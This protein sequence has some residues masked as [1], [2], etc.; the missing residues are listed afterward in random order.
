MLAAWW[1]RPNAEERKRA[2]WAILII[3]ALLSAFAVWNYLRPEGF[4]EWLNG[5]GVLTFRTDAIVGGGLVHRADGTFR[6]GGLL[7]PNTLGYTALV[8]VC[9]VVGRVARN[10]VKRLDAA[11]GLLCAVA[12][13]MTGS[14]SAIAVLPVVGLVIAATSG[15][16]GRAVGVA[17]GTAVVLFI[18]AGLVGGVGETLSS[19]TD[20]NNA[21]TSRHIDA[22]GDGVERIRTRPFGSGLGTASS[23]ALKYQ[24]EGAQFY[25]ESALI[26]VG[27]ETGVIGLVAFLVFVGATLRALALESRREPDGLALAA[28][29]VVV[30]LF[31][32]SLVLDVFI[33]V[34]PTWVGFVVV[35]IGLGGAPVRS[36]ERSRGA[37]ALTY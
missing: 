25:T 4:S 34:A 18:A 27:T 11:I 21:S 23:L 14:R 2:E 35:G 36:P 5:S 10:E 26:H 12:I 32:G 3:G 22:W 37:R 8:S 31:L 9:V 29:G 16:L 13:L 6:A 33:Q 15:R 7:P 30:A 28:L 17:A 1:L 19:G 20:S 24:V